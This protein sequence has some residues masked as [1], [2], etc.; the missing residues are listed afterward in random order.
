M[1]ELFARLFGWERDETLD[2]LR[3]RLATHRAHAARR[4]DA[5][6]ARARN[7]ETGHYLGDRAGRRLGLADLNP[8]IGEQ[9]DRPG[10]GDNHG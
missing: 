6:I 5:V 1:R 10:G 8:G 4:E 9:S 3:Q 7:L 2:D